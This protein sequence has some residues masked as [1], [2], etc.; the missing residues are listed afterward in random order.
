MV[1]NTLG[2]LAI[3]IS[4]RANFVFMVFYTLFALSAIFY[5]FKETSLQH[6]KDKI[7]PL[8]IKNT[9]LV[10]LKNRVFMGMT[11]ATFLSYGAVFAWQTTGP[12]LLIRNLNLSPVA[13]GWINFFAGAFAFATGGRLNGKLVARLG[14]P[15]M[16][17]TGWG[18]MIVSAFLMLAGKVFLSTHVFAIVI[19]LIL[20]YFGSTFIFPN[21]FATAFTPFGHIAGFTAALYGFMQICGAAVLAALMST[22]PHNNAMPLSIV[23]LCASL[24]SWLIYEVFVVPQLQ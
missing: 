11:S 20:F 17:R 21:A 2:Y 4:W 1:S 3:G 15:F 12:I 24:L 9:Y 14:M 5:G 22:L 23:M 6:H 18:I 10:L 7:R 8:Y 16:L 13:F 19:P